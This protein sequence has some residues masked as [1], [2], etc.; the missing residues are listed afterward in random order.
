MEA[1]LLACS[2]KPNTIYNSAESSESPIISKSNKAFLQNTIVR[3]AA[4]FVAV[5]AL[6][7][8][9][10]FIKRSKNELLLWS[11]IDLSIIIVDK[12]SAYLSSLRNNATL[13]KIFWVE[14]NVKNYILSTAAV[15]WVI[16]CS[17]TPK[18]NFHSAII[19]G[20]IERV[21]IWFPTVLSVST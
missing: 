10:V 18:Y 6:K 16:F 4:W 8:P 15:A 1:W 2:E 11:C 13:C 20:T 5:N 12:I 19:Y 21:K 14:P 7:I 9:E 3:F 17:S